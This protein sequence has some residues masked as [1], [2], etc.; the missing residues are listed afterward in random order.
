VTL[1]W[2]AAQVSDEVR[3][4]LDK[5]AARVARLGHS[6]SLVSMRVLADDQVD[7]RPYRVPDPDGDEILRGVESGQLDRL[8]EGFAGHHASKPRVMPSAV[9][10]YREPRSVRTRVPSSIFGASWD[11]WII[12]ACVNDEQEPRLPASRSVDI[13]RAVRGALQSH[14]TEQPPAEILSGHQ[15]AGAPSE[16]PHLAIVPLPFVGM[17]DADGDLRGVALIFP[18]TATATER[19]SVLRAVG[20]WEQS[21]RANRDV[22]PP[23]HV[24]ILLAGRR[25]LWVQRQLTPTLHTLQSA[26]WC[27]PA[28]QWATVTPIALDHHPGDLRERD[29]EKLA[30]AIA[31]AQ[32]SIVEA[33]HRIGLPAPRVEIHPAAPIV[34]GLKT[35]DFPAY[36]PVPGRTRR[37]LTHAVLEFAQPVA[38]PILLGAGRYHGLGLLHP[39]DGDPA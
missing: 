22:E 5:L 14:S 8:C 1:I 35:R 24:P 6:S 33:C 19:S 18:R 7:A 37:A 12:L 10:V 20:A 34:G 29:S 16:R 23:A 4:A 26:R 38:G 2:P 39:C 15:P 32:D 28:R 9:H 13:A 30:K 3:V 31:A 25:E 17:R 11:D 36:P 27:G 21:D